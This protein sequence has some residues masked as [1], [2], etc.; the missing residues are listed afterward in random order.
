MKHK[1][2]W[3]RQR[4]KQY[5]I[6]GSRVIDKTCAT[7]SGWRGRE[8]TLWLEDHPEVKDYVVLDDNS[9][10]VETHNDK[11]VK[12]TWPVGLTLPHTFEV[13]KR[14]GSKPDLIDEEEEC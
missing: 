7:F 11:F 10:I 14:F 3:I 2:S 6:D 12:T 9:L 13:L 1:L 5:G 8:I 4:M